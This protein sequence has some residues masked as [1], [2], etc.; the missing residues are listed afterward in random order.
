MKK[1]FHSS[2]HFIENA[3][4]NSTYALTNEV[5]SKRVQG[6]TQEHADKCCLFSTRPSAREY[7]RGL[8]Y[9]G[10][11]EAQACVTVKV[12]VIVRFL[13][14]LLKDNLTVLKQLVFLFIYVAYAT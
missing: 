2:A 4:C 7:T 14:L 8:S 9:L 11:S 10:P 13:H 1:S 6:N 12:V 5:L 3:K